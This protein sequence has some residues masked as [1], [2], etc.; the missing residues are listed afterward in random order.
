MIVVAPEVNPIRHRSHCRPF[1]VLAYIFCSLLAVAEVRFEL[2][3]RDIVL[4]R[5]RS[6]PKHDVDRE[7]QL[8]T[9]FSAV[10]CNEASLSIDLG[11]HSKFGNVIC[12]LQGSSP[13]EIVV[14]AH[15]DH[16]EVG[17]GAVDNWSGTSLL[18]SL[19]ESLHAIP[20]KHTF[21]F[22]GFYGEEQGLLGSRY[23]VHRLSKEQL[24]T[25]DAMVNLD[26]FSVGPTQVWAGHGDPLLEQA[27]I[28]IAGAMKLPLQAV[29][30]ENV[31][32]DSETF[33]A[34]Q[35]PS[36]EFC[37]LTQSTRSLLHSPLDQVSQINEDDFYNTY[38]LLAAY[39]AYL[40]QV[41]G[42]RAAGPASTKQVT[43]G[44]RFPK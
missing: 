31:T 41:A 32:T 4:S 27:A 5:L 17:A 14:G 3:A 25:I 35:V 20:R 42:S 19:Y 11:P 30:I 40:D 29:K 15:F 39:L 34:K 38:H 18:P 26:T 23:Y 6:C 9:Y 16:A 44:A 33:R 2:L 21:V 10:G 28:T 12:R 1:L 37:S 8:K 13:E 7:E 43:S 36:I 24:K 22:V